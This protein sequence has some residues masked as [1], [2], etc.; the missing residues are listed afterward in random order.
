PVRIQHV[1]QT[2]LSFICI[3]RNV[4]R[5]GVI[6]WV[7]HHEVAEKLFAQNELVGA[8]TAIGSWRDGRRKIQLPGGIRQR[9]PG[10]EEPLRPTPRWIAAIAAGQV[11]TEVAGPA[12]CESG[13]AQLVQNPHLRRSEA[14]R[15]AHSG[16]ANQLAEVGVT[17][18]R[19]FNN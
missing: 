7:A 5:A 13:L 17:S 16:L 15:S 11:V 19:I 14:G 12:A 10:A 2:A 3:P 18:A 1:P 4:E 9:R 6:V 8:P